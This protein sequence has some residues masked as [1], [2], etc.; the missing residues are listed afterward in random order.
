MKILLTN[1]YRVARKFIAALAKYAALP[2]TH[3]SQNTLSTALSTARTRRAAHVAA[4]RATRVAASKQKNVRQAAIGF[5]TECRDALTPALGRSWS[6]AWIPAGWRSSLSTPRILGALV[7]L[8]E[9]LHG[10]LTANARLENADQNFTA[11]EVQNWLDRLEAAETE[12]SGAKTAQRAAKSAREAAE[13]ALLGQARG[14]VTELELILPQ[15]DERWIE[16]VSE[17]P[18]DEQRPEPVEGVVLT[19]AAPGELDVDWEG[20]PR[21]ERYQVCLK[22]AGVDAEF[23][24]V[25]TVR[26]TNA[27]LTGLTPGAEV[28]VRIVAANA[29]G[30]AAPSDDEAARVPALS[31]AA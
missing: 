20:S 10:F 1:L 6:S 25:L 29:A 9:D 31:A 19:G 27:T 7:T 16:F 21:A 18:S 17:V 8:L 14:L 15:T 3:V 24:H 4:V 23:R 13:A 12:L 26:D 11:V 2:V 22:V 30:E 5:V 28:T